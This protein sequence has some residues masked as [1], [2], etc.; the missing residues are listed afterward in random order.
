MAI[1]AGKIRPLQPD[2]EQMAE[3]ELMLENDISEPD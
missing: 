2:T 3:P 1:E